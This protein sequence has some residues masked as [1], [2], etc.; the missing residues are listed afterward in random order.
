MGNGQ[1]DLQPGKEI[2]DKREKVG[3]GKETAGNTDER[4]DREGE[5]VVEERCRRRNAGSGDHNENQ[6]Q[7]EW[8]EGKVNGKV[9]A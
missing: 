5:S 7:R 3:P 4:V 8:D 2:R 1:S 6:M 9:K